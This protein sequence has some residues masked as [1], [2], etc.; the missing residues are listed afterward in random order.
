MIA[1]SEMRFCLMLLGFSIFNLTPRLFLYE[2]CVYTIDY[3]CIEVFTGVIES[4]IANFVRNF[5]TK[6]D[7]M[8][9]TML[10]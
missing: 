8:L 1:H 3:L 7:M 9:G 6:H 5:D 10:V 2:F 4:S